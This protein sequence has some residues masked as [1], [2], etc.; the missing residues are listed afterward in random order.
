MICG[1]EGWDDFVEFAHAKREWLT[2]RLRLENGIP[3]ADTF[4]RVFARLDPEAFTAGFLRWTQAV[5]E[6]SKASSL[7]VIAVDG[8]TLRH[9]FD[10]A[11]EQKAVHI[12]SAWASESRLVLAQTQVSEKSNEITAVPVLLR[13][14]DIAGCIVTA[15]AMSCQKTIAAQ[16]VEQK[17]DYVLALKGNHARLAEDVALLFAHSEAKRWEERPHSVHTA[18]EAEHG[19]IET[20]TCRV[21]AL[22]D[23]A[24]TWDDIAAEWSGLVC[25][26]EI[27]SKRQVGSKTSHEKRYYLSSVRKGAK[28][29]LKII[30]KHWGIENSVHWVLDVVAHEDACRIRKDHA[31][32]NMATLRHLAL[33]LIR[34]E[35]TH[36]RG[37]KTKIKRAG[38]DNAYLAR[39]ISI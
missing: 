30:R 5:A 23:L 8:K 20:R 11:S 39:L 6:Q 31:P 10:T 12:V 33:N 9:S 19:R 28:A 15:D 26:V 38:W 3:C 1:A 36:K 17:G 37:V 18:L 21:I 27:E 13:M 2:L 14:L 34:Q 16:I 25:L 32:Q 29:H 35:T 7:P 24:G 22:A 4:L